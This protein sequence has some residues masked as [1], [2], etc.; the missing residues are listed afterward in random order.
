[1]SNWLAVF[2][3]REN[4]ASAKSEKQGR[5]GREG[6]GT[7]SILFLTGTAFP[8]CRAMSDHNSSTSRSVGD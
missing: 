5:E 7:P 3:P 8:H 4:E 2:G 1:M 6:E